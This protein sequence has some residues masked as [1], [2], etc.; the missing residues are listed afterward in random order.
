MFLGTGTP[1]RDTKAFGSSILLDLE[2]H[3]ILVDY[4]PATTAKM[5]RATYSPRDLEP[6]LVF[7]PDKVLLSGQALARKG[8]NNETF[9]LWSAG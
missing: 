9:T 1:T 8:K 4:G 2:G 5:A 3:V 6:M 7:V